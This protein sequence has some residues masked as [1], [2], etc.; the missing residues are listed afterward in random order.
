[1]GI[2]VGDYLNNGW[3]DLFNTDFS[4]DYDVLYRNDG[5]GNFTDVSYQ[6][7]VAAPTIPFLGWGDGFLDYDNDGLK[8]LL[9]LNG[10]VY[11]AVDKTSW[12]TTFAQR[13]LLFH[14]LDGSSFT[15]IPPV[16]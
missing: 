16:T 13:P 1:M 8:D 3:L 2:A 15:L 11:P 4:D 12:G 5:D 14:N 6:A 10:H 9:I 7:G